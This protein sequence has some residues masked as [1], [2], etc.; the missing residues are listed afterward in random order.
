LLIGLAGGAAAGALIR[1]VLYGTSPLDPIVFA[2]MIGSL[3]LTAVLAC[4][5]PAFRA[6]KIEPMQALRT[7]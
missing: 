1:S 3:L 6:S 5:I 4:A 2:T 7:E